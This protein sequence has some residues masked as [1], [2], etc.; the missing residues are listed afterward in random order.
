MK[1]LQ[2]SWRADRQGE[3]SALAKLVELYEPEVRI[4]ARLLLGPAL[5]P[6]LDSV[7]LVQSVHG[8]LIRGLRDQKFDFS[9][10][11]QLLG[12]ALTIVRR[13]AAQHWRRAK[14]QQR[15]E[16]RTTAEEESAS[17]LTALYS[18]ET[19]PA[20]VAQA[21]D[22]LHHLLNQLNDVDRRLVGM[23]L[24]GTPVRGNRS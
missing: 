2:A 1:N 7:D 17:V 20:R 23:W 16:S 10:P 24:N 6:Y 14:R 9:S 13:K 8:S 21:N 22:Q 3:P 11:D 5:R 18:R 15:L 4:V 19:D 12:M